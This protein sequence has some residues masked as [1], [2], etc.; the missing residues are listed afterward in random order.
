MDSMKKDL[1]AFLENDSRI[2]TAQGI[3]LICHSDSCTFE[4]LG[5]LSIEDI[6]AA[7]EKVKTSRL[8]GE[9][10]EMIEHTMAQL[11]GIEARYNEGVLSLPGYIGQMYDK[12][13]R[14][15]ERIEGMK[16]DK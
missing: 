4:A 10:F 3:Y 9:Q 11:K 5:E 6:V 1:I 16:G 2:T 12:M 8:Y 14:L 15:T 13:E 7:D